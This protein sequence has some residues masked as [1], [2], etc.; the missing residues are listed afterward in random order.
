[1]GMTFKGWLFALGAAIVLL[2]APH[3]AAAQSEGAAFTVGPA[4]YDPD[5]PATRSYF[6]YDVEPGRSF[7][8]EL[9]VINTG[10]QPG[11]VRLYPVDA[12]TG[13][14]SGPVYLQ[15]DA[16]RRDVGG[17]ITLDVRELRLEPGEEQLAGFS[18][19]VPAGARAGEHLGG[20]VAEGATVTSASAE[21]NF[22]VDLR[23]RSVVAVQVNLPGPR[24]D[25]LGAAG[26]ST[27]VRNGLQVVV[28]SLRNEGTHL[29]KGAG[30]VAIFAASGEQVALVPLRFDSILPGDMLNLQAP[31]PGQALGVGRYRAALTLTAD[32]QGE[33]TM[34]TSHFDVTPAQVE[35]IYAAQP[36]LP[37]APAPTQLGWGGRLPLICGAISL[38]FF[39]LYLARRLR[40]STARAVN[41]ES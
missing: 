9:R 19:A 7:H 22:A 37:P 29:A 26:L 30:S 6:V 16:Q 23:I 38:I 41:R 35:T 5:R 27:A 17:W 18:V 1:M 8:D 13:Q 40:P 33:P 10:D 31:V 11:V 21:S 36:Q 24:V 34:L 15:A 2:T 32:G 39:T 14:N 25:K 20:I 4:R 12:T 3:G 28:V